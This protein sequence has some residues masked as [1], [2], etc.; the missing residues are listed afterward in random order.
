MSL[1]V[2]QHRIK[3]HRAKQQEQSKGVCGRRCIGG[4]GRVWTRRA[5]KFSLSELDVEPGEGVS[6]KVS[7]PLLYIETLSGC[8][9]EMG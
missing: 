5:G 6:R 4:E 7:A 2:S 9:G 3:Q 8:T 1:A